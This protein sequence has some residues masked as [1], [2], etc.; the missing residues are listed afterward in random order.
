ML[1]MLSRFSYAL[2]VVDVSFGVRERELDG[3]WDYIQSPGLRLLHMQARPFF[4]FSTPRLLHLSPSCRVSR[5]PTAP[6]P[7]PSSWPDFGRAAQSSAPSASSPSPSPQPPATPSSA[8]D[9][10][11]SLLHSCGL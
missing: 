10:H 2:K 6:S 9:C 8:Q 3:Q 4:P 7:R 5:R 11:P 1:V